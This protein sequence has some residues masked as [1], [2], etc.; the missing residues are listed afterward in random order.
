MFQMME[1]SKHEK[2]RQL[3]EKRVTNALKALQLVGNLSN[4]NN[5]SYEPEEVSK[6]IAALEA[7]LK[8]VKSKF[9]NSKTQKQNFKL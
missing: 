6:I 1:K 7:E 5:Y 2:F 8:A 4:R 9:Q 3:A